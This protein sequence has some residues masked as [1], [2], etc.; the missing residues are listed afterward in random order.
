[1]AFDMQDWDLLSRRPLNLDRGSSY[2]TTVEAPASGMMGLLHR[3]LGRAKDGT[4][5]QQVHF[6]NIQPRPSFAFGV[7]TNH[8]DDVPFPDT[9]LQMMSG[10]EMT[11]MTTGGN[12]VPFLRSYSQATP[13]NVSVPGNTS[14]FDLQMAVKR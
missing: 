13:V 11:E 2:I 12:H 3:D 9:P 14:T 8:A 6:V 5:L 4:C 1:M 7:T 10:N